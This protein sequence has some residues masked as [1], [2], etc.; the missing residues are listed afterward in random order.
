MSDMLEKNLINLNAFWQTLPTEKNE[1]GI[2]YHLSWPHKIWKPKFTTIS[3][4]KWHE[5][6]YVTLDKPTLKHGIKIKVQLTAMYL[7]LKKVTGHEHEQVS[8]VHSVTGLRK[9][10]NACSNA[11]GYKIDSQALVPLINDKN[12]TILAFSINEKIAGTAILYQSN[13]TMGIH[14]VGV[15]PEFQKRG[16]GKAIM[17]HL[18]TIAKSK[19]CNTITLQASQAGM[20]MYLDMGFIKL[21]ELYHFENN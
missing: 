5:K 8:I 10:S 11:F 18:I 17:L 1:E 13:N 12:A 6:V 20:H 7:E 16:I 19:L 21:A 9:W 2:N 4:D 3:N 15:L 14:Q